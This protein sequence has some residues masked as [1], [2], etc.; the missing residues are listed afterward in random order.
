MDDRV[1]DHS[2]RRMYDNRSGGGGK[3]SDRRDVSAN[4]LCHHIE[5]TEKGTLQKQPSRQPRINHNAKIYPKK[6]V[7]VVD[8]VVGVVG[9]VAAETSVLDTPLYIQTTT[10]TTIPLTS[11]VVEDF[12]IVNEWQEDSQEDFGSISEVQYEDA[13]AEYAIE[14][15]RDQE[16]EQ[17]VGV[18][19]D[20]TNTLPPAP[21]KKRTTRAKHFVVE[22][23]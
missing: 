5:Q 21:R 16:S 11:Q 8:V 15:T 2:E 10:T 23:F 18:V 6:G 17:Q 13:A 19:V 4:K 22:P 7:D 12:P 14:R 3:G 9:V 1:H 20:Y